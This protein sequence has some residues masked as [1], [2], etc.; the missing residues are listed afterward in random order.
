LKDKAKDRVLIAEETATFM[1]TP[2]SAQNRAVLAYHPTGL[3][4][5]VKITF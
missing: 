2:A 3:W 4:V 5:E 1:A